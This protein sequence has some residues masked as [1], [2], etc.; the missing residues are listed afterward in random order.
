VYYN[1]S[2]IGSGFDDPTD[3]NGVQFGVD[4]Y[5]NYGEELTFG[6][7]IDELTLRGSKL[8][9]P[10]LVPSYIWINPNPGWPYDPGRFNGPDDETNEPE[11]Q[12][13]LK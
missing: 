6:Q 5:K 9:H 12:R 3:F 11:A 7:L 8:A 1:P 13:L 2:W 4:L 10:V